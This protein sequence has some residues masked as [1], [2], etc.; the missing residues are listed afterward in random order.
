MKSPA[1]QTELDSLVN[2][3][4]FWRMDRAP[5]MQH[6]FHF[7]LYANEHWVAHTSNFTENAWAWRGFSQMVLEDSHF[8]GL[9]PRLSAGKNTK[10]LKRDVTEH[11]HKA[12]LSILGR[13]RPQLIAEQLD[14]IFQACCEKHLTNLTVIL[15]DF[16]EDIKASLDELLHLAVASGGLD[17]VK[18][19][20]SRGANVDAPDEESNTALHLAIIVGDVEVIRELLA[21]GADP[22]AQAMRHDRKS[23]LYLATDLANL[24]LVELLLDAGAKFTASL[25]PNLMPSILQKTSASGRLGLVERLVVA[26]AYV[27]EGEIRCNGLTLFIAA[28]EGRCFELAYHLVKTG[29]NVNFKTSEDGHTALQAA[30]GAGNTVPL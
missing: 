11:N 5:K 1:R 12:L 8:A 19:L 16:A 2:A 17:E 6:P 22:N 24:K 30:A 15:L 9:P 13:Y 27:S 7:L 21:A 25:A 3:A 28:V 14:D 26:G 18:L 10:R 29:A 23:A 20:I 4:E